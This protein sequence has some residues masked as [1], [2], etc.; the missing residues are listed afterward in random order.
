MWLLRLLSMTWRIRVHG[1]D[2]WRAR[3]ARGDSAVVLTLWHGQMLPIL[4]AH[5][6]EPCRVLVSEHRD[7]EIIARVLAAF[8]FGAVR[9]SSSRGGTRALL[10][11]AQVVQQGD[12][13]AI[14]PDGPRGPNRSVAPGPLLIAQRTGVPLVPLV[15]HTD[16][17]W[18]L[19]SWDAFEIPKPFARVTVVYGT[20]LR[21]SAAS[22]R[23]AAAQ[24]DRVRDAMA[25]TLTECVAR[26]GGTP[27]D[28]A[29]ADGTSADGGAVVESP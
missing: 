29:P 15:A 25:A 26:H 14:T 6:G 10:Q 4:V 28:G 1:R 18:R 23:D 17:C 9:G 3:R 5:R 22:A 12:D 7:G 24:V 8:G 21:L 11:L 16:R 27:A 2:G 20:P 13:I 19:R